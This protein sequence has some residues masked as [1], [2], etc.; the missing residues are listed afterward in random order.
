MNQQIESM[1]YMLKQDPGNY[2]QILLELCK[3]LNDEKGN[4]EK[5]HPTKNAAP[6]PSSSE[7]EETGKYFCTKN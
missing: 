5:T 6:A 7:S 3:Q 2:K 1:E 4:H